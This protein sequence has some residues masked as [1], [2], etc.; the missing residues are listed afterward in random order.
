VEYPPDLGDPVVVRRIVSA[1]TDL[2]LATLTHGVV[3]AAMA[4]QADAAVAATLI[5]EVLGMAA[6]LVDNHDKRV[7]TDAVRLWRVAFV[8][9]ILRPDSPSPAAARRSL[10]RYLRA[11]ELTVT[12]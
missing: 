10:R 4:A 7:A 6:A 9:A 1:G 12:D 2:Q 11:L 8:P 5:V 3:G